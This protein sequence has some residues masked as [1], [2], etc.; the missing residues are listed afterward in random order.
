MVMAIATVLALIL[1]GALCLLAANGFR[2]VSSAPAQPYMAFTLGTEST[3]SSGTI[4][5][6]IAVAN[7]T[8]SAMTGQ[9]RVGPADPGGPAIQPWTGTLSVPS[10]G[11]AS[12]DAQIT[13]ACGVRLSVSLDTAADHR[14]LIAFVPCPPTSGGLP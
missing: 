13:K 12:A 7:A 11:A 14:S 2:L 9:L 5:L 3:D 6:N 1:F 4:R 10:N 8:P